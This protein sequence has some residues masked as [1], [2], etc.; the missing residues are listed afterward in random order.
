MEE[1][2]KDEARLKALEVLTACKG[3]L[4]VLEKAAHMFTDHLETKPPLDHLWMGISTLAEEMTGQLED[5]CQFLDEGIMRGVNS[6][7][8]A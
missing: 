5:V 6:A 4:W 7:E 3:K 8:E 1:T 2:D